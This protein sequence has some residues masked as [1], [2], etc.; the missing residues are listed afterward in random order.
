MTFLD[1]KGF[2][3]YIIYFRKTEFEICG[4]PHNNVS[5]NMKTLGT[6]ITTVQKL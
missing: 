5:G 6:I 4:I 1:L 3:F 2:L